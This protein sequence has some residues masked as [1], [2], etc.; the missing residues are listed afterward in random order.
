[1]LKIINSNDDDDTKYIGDDPVRPHIPIQNRIGKNQKIFLLYD[2]DKIQAITCVSF[3]NSVPVDED[4]LFTDEDDINLV[5]FYTIW[6]YV[7]G[8]ARDLLFSVVDYIKENLPEVKRF[9]T[10]SPKTEM[11]KKFHLR[12]GAFIFSENETSINYEYNRV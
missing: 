7:P 10:L 12:N 3:N 6:S 2:G 9:V 4:T 1:M 11:A 5:V 8:K